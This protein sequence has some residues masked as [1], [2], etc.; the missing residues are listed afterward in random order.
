[1]QYN[2]FE[3]YFSYFFDGNQDTFTLVAKL[4]CVR[5]GG[6]ITSVELIVN[7]YLEEWAPAKS[8]TE[9]KGT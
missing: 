5:E 4:Y 8:M 3:G 1:M 9:I 6:A 7:E 2:N